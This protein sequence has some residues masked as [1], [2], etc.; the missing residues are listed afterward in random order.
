MAQA[1]VLNNLYNLANQDPALKGKLKFM[2]VGKDNDEM[3]MKM[4]KA[5]HKVPFPMIADPG[6][7]FAKALNFPNYP[8]TMLLDKSGKIIWVHVGAFDNAEEALKN[9]K[10]VVK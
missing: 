1:P 2:A 4:W 3:A 6:G 7:M 10:A 9:I 5:F 8:V